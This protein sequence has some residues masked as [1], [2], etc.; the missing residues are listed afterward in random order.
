MIC[1]HPGLAY[2]SEPFNVRI[3][4]SP[5]RHFFH[6][7]TPAEA[8][9]FH[10]YLEPLLTFHD[11]AL[12]QIRDSGPWPTV[13]RSGRTIRA[14]W[15]R[16]RNQRPLMKD[17]IAFFSAEWLARTFGADVVVMIRHPAGFAR[18]LLRLGSVFDFNDLLNQPELIRVHRLEEFEDDIRA[19]AHQPPD[20]L[21]Q[22]ILLWQIFATVILRYRR[23]HPGWTFLR[24]E[25]MSSQPILEFAS[26]LPRLGL[27]L[28]PGVL[29]TVKEYTST[30]NPSDAPGN[31]AHHLK[32]NSRAN[33]WSWREKLRAAEVDRIRRGTERLARL[34][35]PET[36]W[37]AN[38]TV[39][40][41][42]PVLPG[43]A[44]LGA[45][46]RRLQAQ[47]ETAAADDKV[48]R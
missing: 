22:A 36:D 24:H 28:T 7:V 10:G 3:P 4:P 32:R 26:L 43:L 42:A 29:R 6:H 41:I 13:R 23:E 31:V 35:Y 2:L 20:L 5:I 46:G 15:R 8:Q 44:P 17:P 34:F 11:A 12:Y 33:A 30:E 19:Y 18:S 39:E 21:Q 48:A 40:S 9:A 45:A 38:G 1:S 25:D 14:W 16:W 47:A 37:T 27:E